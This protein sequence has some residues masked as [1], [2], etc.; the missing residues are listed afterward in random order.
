M[1]SESGRNDARENRGCRECT[2]EGFLTRCQCRG[3]IRTGSYGLGRFGLAD[4]AGSGSSGQGTCRRPSGGRE[5][6]PFVAVSSF[7]EL[8]LESGEW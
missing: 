4:R 6:C 7:L 5:G 1:D 3:G 8:G 2:L